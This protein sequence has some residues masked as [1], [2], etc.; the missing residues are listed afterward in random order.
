[1]I[2]DPWLLRTRRAK[3]DGCDIEH[4]STIAGCG[5][6]RLPRLL[7]L[8]GHHHCPAEFTVQ[9]PALL[10]FFVVGSLVRAFVRVRCAS[11]VLPPKF[12]F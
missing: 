5:L 11:L 1:M 8:S 6:S 3:R 9:L 7:G 4:R 10:L 12:D 2:N